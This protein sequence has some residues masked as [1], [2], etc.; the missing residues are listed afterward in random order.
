M[1]TDRKT[2]REF[3][4]RKMAAISLSIIA[5]LLALSSFVNIGLHNF[6]VQSSLAAK[7]KAIHA[8]ASRA[9][10]NSA[11]LPEGL[12]GNLDARMFSEQCVPTQ[13][14]SGKL[15]SQ[16][17]VVTWLSCDFNSK[18]AFKLELL[19]LRVVGYSPDMTLLIGI[20]GDGRLIFI[21]VLEHHETSSFGA[22]LVATDSSW[23]KQL[24]GLSRDSFS[25]PLTGPQLD[26]VSG[27]TITANAIVNAIGN[28]Y[29]VLDNANF[30][31]E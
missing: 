18:S 17:E 14:A 15:D 5:V 20:D 29:R 2:H 27:A 31:R 23:L 21:E 12:N 26:A 25:A 11:N 30:P 24:S 16:F 1:A 8:L 13:S 3:S 9:V 6:R 19:K 4:H 7:D 10:R 22:E 28:S